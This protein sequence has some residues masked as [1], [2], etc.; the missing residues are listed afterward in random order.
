MIKEE[1]VEVF[2]KL[3]LGEVLFEECNWRIKFLNENE[4]APWRTVGP[5][6][7]CFGELISIN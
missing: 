7:K 1:C 6:D 2:G 4:S 3:P 5:I